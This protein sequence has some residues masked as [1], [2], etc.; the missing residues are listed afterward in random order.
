MLVKNIAIIGAGS[1]IGLEIAKKLKAQGAN[2][3]LTTRSEHPEVNELS[4]NVRVFD[5]NN[6][7]ESL[8]DFWPQELH[9]FVYCPGTISLK[10]FN[11]FSADDFMNDFKINALGA[12]ITIQSAFKNLKKSG[13]ASIVLFSTVAVKVGMGFHSSIGMAKGAVEG[14]GKSLAAELAPNNVRVNII[15]PSLTDTPLA[16]SLL[17]SP[18]KKEAAGKRHPLGRV[19]APADLASTAVFLLQEEASWITGQI[20]GVDGGLSSLK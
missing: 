14:L 5:V 15:A 13:N 8:A 6:S 4:E 16:N 7:V 11:R 17:S 2:L 1:G 18:E 12:A 19:G 9:G 3:Y 10:P 20:I